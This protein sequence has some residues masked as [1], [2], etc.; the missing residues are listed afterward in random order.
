MGLRL[1]LTNDQIYALIM[2]LIAAN[3]DEADRLNLSLT[4]PGIAG[5]KLVQWFRTLLKLGAI[6]LNPPDLKT[7][8]P[9]E[10]LT[11]KVESEA[12]TPEKPVEDTAIVL[13]KGLDRT[14]PRVNVK[15]PTGAL[16]FPNPSFE[17]VLVTDRQTSL[18]TLLS[19]RRECIP[20]PELIVYNNG[21]VYKQQPL[22]TSQ[23]IAI[24][25]KAVRVAYPDLISGL[26]ALGQQAIFSYDRKTSPAYLSPDARKNIQPLCMR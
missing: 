13:P 17:P 22:Q 11:A 3:K 14:L 5:D 2:G 24:K 16:V 21:R 9:V 25:M 18:S 4:P 19:I 20:L 12:F 23:P 6:T 10:V 8:K 7:I 15:N 1:D 26:M